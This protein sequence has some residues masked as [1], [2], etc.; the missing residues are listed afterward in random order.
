MLGVVFFKI[1]KY[2]TAHKPCSEFSY[3]ETFPFLEHAELKSQG[4]FI[5][6]ITRNELNNT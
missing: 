3:T 1:D 4:I 6:I 5:V 2:D